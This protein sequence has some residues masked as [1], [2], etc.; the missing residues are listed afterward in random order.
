MWNFLIKINKR[1]V[2]VIPA[3]LGGVLAPRLIMSG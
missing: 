2:A 3:I 1:L